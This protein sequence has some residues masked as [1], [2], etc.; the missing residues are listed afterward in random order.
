MP[1]FAPISEHVDVSVY[2]VLQVVP[3]V[4]GLRNSDILFAVFEHQ[5]FLKCSTVGV[6]Q[7]HAK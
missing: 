7:F 2:A 6:R 3:Q 1:N 4:Q 5:I